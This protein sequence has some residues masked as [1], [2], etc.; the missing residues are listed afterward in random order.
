MATVLVVEDDPVIQNLLE[1]NLELDGH[2]VVLA[3]DGIEGVERA[4]EVRPDV[5][6]MD[7][8]M[9]RMGGV[10]ACAALRAE[11]AFASTPIVFL[12]AKAQER[13]RQEGLAAGATAYV[14]KPFD[15]LD[16]LDLVGTLVDGGDP[17]VGG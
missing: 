17:P 15:P 4:R 9:P 6:L 12:S 13:D 3:G 5:I 7:V 11:E 14:T 2:E 10:E 1:I 8:M 16:L